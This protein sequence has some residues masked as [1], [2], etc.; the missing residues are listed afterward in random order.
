M[1]EGNLT[2]M[3]SR[4]VILGSRLEARIEREHPATHAQ[5]S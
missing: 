2:F 4:T 5:E 3:Y 1:G